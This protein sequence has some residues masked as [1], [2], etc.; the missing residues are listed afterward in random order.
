MEVKKFTFNYFSENTYVL[1][2][3]SKECAIIDAGCCNA[4]EEKI[5]TQF[6]EDQALNPVLLLNTHAHIDHILGNA[7]VAK[8]YNL[9]L[10]LHKED[11]ETLKSGEFVAKKYGFPYNASPLPDYFLEPGK[12]ISFGHTTL[13]IRFTPGHSPGSVCF[14]HHNDKVVLGGDVL[15]RGSIGRTDL[16]GGDLQTLLQSI[17]TQ[18][19]V[20]DEGY[21][22]YSG[23]GED[24]NIGFEKKYN[25][26]VRGEL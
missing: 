23:H 14:I 26:F 15:F 25:P 12:N 18:L 9:K 17:Q 10:H 1:F 5:L 3:E 19:Y 2:D 21:T 22:V 6:I 13:E 4:S 24:T 7:F 8:R 16:P 20:L 11:L